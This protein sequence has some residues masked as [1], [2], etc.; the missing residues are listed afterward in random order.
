MFFFVVFLKVRPGLFD[1][2]EEEGCV[3]DLTGRAGDTGRLLWY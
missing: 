1:F 3:E 2:Y